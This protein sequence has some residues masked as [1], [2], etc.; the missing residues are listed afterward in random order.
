MEWKILWTFYTFIF[1]GSEERERESE[2]FVNFV[3]VNKGRKIFLLFWLLFTRF[4]R[5]ICWIIFSNDIWPYFSW[6][7]FQDDSSGVDI[8]NSWVGSWRLLHPSS[9]G[10]YSRLLD[11]IHINDVCWVF[12]L[13]VGDE[14]QHFGY[15][16]KSSNALSSLHTTV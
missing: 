4:I 2:G 6:L 12:Y 3:L 9:L 7:F 15:K 11:N 13:L 1:K 5:N 10:L 8:G 16:C 14:R